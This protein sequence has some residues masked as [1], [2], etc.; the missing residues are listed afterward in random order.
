MRSRGSLAWSGR[1]IGLKSA[2]REVRSD[3]QQEGFFER[4][5]RQEFL[6]WEMIPPAL[7]F[8]FAE[9]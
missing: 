1:A 9:R 8:C 7:L 5:R 4:R 3:Q 2:D 6:S